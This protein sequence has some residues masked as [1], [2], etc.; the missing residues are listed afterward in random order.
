MDP[1]LGEIKMVGFNFAPNGWAICD[2]SLLAISQNTALFSLLGT[3]YGGDGIRTFALPDLRG[4]VPINAGTGLGLP[5]FVIGQSAGTENVSLLA[6]NLPAHAHTIAPPVSNGNATTGSPVNGY[7]ALAVTNI[8][9]GQ[10]GETAATNT[11]AAGATSGQTQAG[12]Q[13]GATGNNLP[14]SVMQPYLVVN[15]IIAL[16]GIFPS[17]G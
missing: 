4:R 8:T 14:V 12:Y 15:F 13:S 16:T 17:R 5:T 3:T 2:G 9:G 11:Y 6:S 1:F 10:R 7:P